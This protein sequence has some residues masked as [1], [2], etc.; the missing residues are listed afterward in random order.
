MSVYG[1][2]PGERVCKVNFS[3][4]SD[5]EKKN[6]NL[7]LARQE[8]EIVFEEEGAHFVA[9]IKFVKSPGKESPA[10]HLQR[11]TGSSR[12]PGRP[13]SPDRNGSQH[14]KARNTSGSPNGSK[15]QIARPSR[16]PVPTTRNQSK[17]K[18][19]DNDKG[20]YNKS[21]PRNTT[22]NRDPSQSPPRGGINNHEK[23]DVIAEYQPRFQKNDLSDQSFRP[24]MIGK[25]R[26]VLTTEFLV[27]KIEEVY[28]F[29]VDRIIRHHSYDSCASSVTDY[30]WNKYQRNT[31]ASFLPKVYFHQALINLLYSLKRLG[32]GNEDVTFFDRMLVEEFNFNQF[33]S[34]LNYREIFQT[35]TKITIM[36]SRLLPRPR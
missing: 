7:L 20:D 22:S 24:I 2:R 9:N 5:A 25:S 33:I 15:K 3:K 27:E 31:V 32:K 26:S 1:P 10:R 30:L 16:P 12:S 21:K 28:N 23:L 11:L 17:S 36:G 13:W 8:H 35:I 6:T 4:L 34:F 14:D 19:R 29:T 18:D